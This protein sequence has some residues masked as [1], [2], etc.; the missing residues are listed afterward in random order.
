M[1]RHSAKHFLYV[2]SLSFF[3]N[4]MNRDYYFSP[5]FLGEKTKIRRG[6]DLV[7]RSRLVSSRVEVHNSV[8]FVIKAY[9]QKDHTK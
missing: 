8:V 4:L 3:Y 9:V 1:A 6:R 5:T 2:T 7:P